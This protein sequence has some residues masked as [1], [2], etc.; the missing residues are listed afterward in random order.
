ML[1]AH[2]VVCHDYIIH[3]DISCDPG[4][5]CIVLIG[6]SIP[7]MFNNHTSYLNCQVIITESLPGLVEGEGGTFTFSS[8]TPDRAERVTC[9]CFHLL[10]WFN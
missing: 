1:S 7:N 3:Q 4:H 8:L 2:M 9:Q 6:V 10:L 5:S